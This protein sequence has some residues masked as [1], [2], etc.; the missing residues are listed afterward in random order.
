MGND[1]NTAGRNKNADPGRRS[2]A[3]WACCSFLLLFFLAACDKPLPTFS[4]VDP[5]RSGVLFS[6]QLDYTE[7]YNPYTYRNF[8]NG[9]GVA[10]GDINNDGLPDIYFTGNLVPN[11]LYLNKGDLVFEDITEQAGVACEGV[12][13]SGVNF[14]DINGDGLLDLY[15][16][17]AG[18]P[19]GDNR[20]NELFIN[21]G[22]LTFTEQSREYGL[23]ITGLSIQS[24]FFDYDLDGDLDCY[25]LNNSLRSVGGFDMKEG[26]RDTYDP[27]GNKLLENRDGKFVDVTREAGIY[28]SSI[29]YGLGIT[30]ADFNWDG[31]PDIFLSNDFFEKDYLYLNNQDGTFT[32][33]VDSSFSS[34]SMGS[35]GADA[36][37]LDNDLL[38]EIFVTEML[39]RDADRKKTKTVY[40]NWDKYQLAVS[41]G[42][43]HQFA[44]NVL[45]KNLG[46]DQ[47]VELGRLAG[48]ESSDWSWSALIQDFD[49]D[50]L[51]DIFISN[52]IKSDLLDKD[53]LNFMANDA[54][55]KAMIEEDQEVVKNLID[56]MPSI[57][58]RNAIF[59]NEGQLRFSYQSL[60][61]GFDQATFSNGSAYGDLDNDGDL[62]LVMNNVDQVAT[63]YRN[64]SDRATAHGLSV[65][66]EYQGNNRNAVGAKVIVLSDS[67]R[68]LFEYYPAKGFQSCSAVPPFF[69]LG[70]R[71][72]VDS[73]FVIWP[74]GEISL[75][76]GV[77][78]DEIHTINYQSSER[79]VLPEYLLPRSETAL[80]PAPDPFHFT[81]EEIDLNLFNRER[82]LLSMP[83]HTGPVV[84]AA[85]LN[86]D[87]LDEVFIGG[88]KNQESVLYRS[89]GGGYV[90]ERWF[91]DTRRSEV[92]AAEFFDSDGDGDLDLYV[93]HGGKAFSIYSPEL[94]DVLYLNDGNGQLTL[95]AEEFPFPYPLSTEDIAI[96]D[97]DQDGLPDIVVGE[98]MKTNGH[99]LP[100]SCLILHNEGG[101][102][103]SLDENPLGKDLGMITAVEC[104]DINADGWN[105]IL[106]AGQLMPVIIL[107]NEEGSFRSP[108]QMRILD[109]SEGLWN[110]IETKDLDGDGDPDFVLG[111]LGQNNFFN[112]GLTIFVNDFDGNGTIEQICCEITE[113]GHYPI[114]DID[115]L[116]SQM[117]VLKK[118]HRT[119]EAFSHA[120]LETLVPEDLL[121]QSLKLH[122]TETRSLVF[123]NEDGQLQP[124]ALPREVQYSTVNA[125]LIDDL[126][127]D[128]V[129][130]LMVGGNDY[131]VKPQFG[132]QDAALGWLCLGDSQAG[133]LRFSDCR[134]LGVKGQIR[135]IEV[136]N[137][138]QVIVGVN[139]GE[140][141][142]YE[143]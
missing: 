34:L 86:G 69:G 67:L 93:G 51:R 105:D 130:D 112:A 20:H 71:R 54:R 127:G 26:L 85:D 113:D 30:L 72:Q 136:I 118:K 95:A 128:G 117:P 79:A 21:N 73:L 81:H 49:N 18:K 55:V 3:S 46:G 22:D 141:E 100:G 58:V 109:H 6:N 36:S 1:L 116:Y 10:V 31:W 13:S 62:D 132:R 114:H 66:L 39:P 140:I 17:K 44:R 107:F 28:S 43:H 87:G 98:A 91:A 129:Q 19:E 103:Y 106:L 123:W 142:V 33:R 38:P 83:G 122:L 84:A 61:W 29:G 96:A 82:M 77:P 37:D 32:E 101:N 35:M 25:L 24:A 27:E 121:E 12:W 57:P 88:G 115:E 120:P 75:Q 47:F 7:D 126:N 41:K 139:N 52:G 138:N 11:K 59:R 9:G 94:H 2:G 131:S 76:T 102:R 133:A 45:H 111:N 92:T 16:C 40:E 74:N 23:D 48:V 42:Y 64:N 134:P 60:N 125:I 56:A 135:S 14:V 65:N 4:V 90:E 78:A 89:E 143:F 110:S 70:S 68:A 124:K 80:K 137:E 53:Y 108:E 99:G 15:V 97:L 119:Y 5:D 104:A 63:I 8:Y 50:G